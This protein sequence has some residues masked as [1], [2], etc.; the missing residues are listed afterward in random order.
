[1]SKPRTIMI[2]G[3]SSSTK[4]SQVY[5]L[6]KYINKKYN[7]IGRIIGANASDSAP[8]EESGMLDKG[9]VDFFD[10]SN[11][12]MALADM[13]RLSE[14]YW[15]VDTQ[16]GVVKGYFKSDQ[17]CK[18]RP[19]NLGFMIAEGTTG[20]ASLLLNHIRSQDEGVGF[21]HSYKYEEEGYVIGGLQEGHYGL[22][23]QEMYKLI[24]QGFACLPIKY[25]I[26]TG[27]V[28]KGEEKRT[29]TTVYGP[30][31]AGHATTYEIP[32]WF[33]DV[34]HLDKVVEEV[35]MEGSN[36]TRQVEFRV[37][38]FVNHPD[39]NTGIDYL[40]K[41]RILPELYPELLKR[42]PGGYVKLGFKQGLN[43]FYEAVDE[44]VG[45]YQ[46]EQENGTT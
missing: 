27:L 41:A 21:K 22:V 11:R 33:M 38:W 46:K 36:E 9:I 29:S 34:F 40:A 19:D 15:P 31:A 30:K 43:K 39:V 25:M 3:E 16:D 13:R 12:Q 23:Q 20:V 37:A 1:M 35:K 14:G 26:W 8:F 24:V 6:A 4:T 10:I 2:Y 42:F 44:I 28:G 17:H 18:A 5:H 32:S 7:V 45:K